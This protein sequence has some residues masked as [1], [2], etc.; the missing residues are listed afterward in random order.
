LRREKRGEKKNRPER[1]G[2]KKSGR[3]AEAR[4]AA[5]P[6]RGNVVTVVGKKGEET[7]QKK[8]RGKKEESTGIHSSTQ[9]EK[10]AY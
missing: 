10:G 1:E 7:S 4:D 3:M 6:F 8:G 2:R 9:E 5:M